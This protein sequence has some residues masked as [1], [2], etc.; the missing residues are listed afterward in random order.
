[1]KTFIVLLH[2][3]VGWALCGSI[4]GFGRSV[5]SMENTLIIHVILVPVVFAVVSLIYFKKF[6]YTTP[7]QTAL[8][9]LALAVVMDAVIVAQFIE[10]SYRMFLSPLGTWIPLASIFVVTYAVGLLMRR[11]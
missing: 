7:L 8:I 3:F 4:I 10:K 6:N 2:A 11:G 9:F 1:M 5:T